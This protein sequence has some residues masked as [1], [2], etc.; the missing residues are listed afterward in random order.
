MALLSNISSPAHRWLIISLWTTFALGGMV[1]L[2]LTL[3]MLL[4]SRLAETGISYLKVGLKTLVDVNT[5]LAS[6][7]FQPS[8][9]R[10]TF[11][12]EAKI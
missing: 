2:A 8:C 1:S 12:T 5:D 6:S 3:S 4:D 10:S 11:T 7:T 9:R